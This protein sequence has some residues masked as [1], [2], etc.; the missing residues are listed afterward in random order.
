MQSVFYA[1]FLAQINVSLMI[2]Y[3]YK[4]LSSFSTFLFSSWLQISAR[5]ETHSKESQFQSSIQ[6]QRSRKCLFLPSS[7]PQ[8]NDKP[9]QVQ[10][11]LLVQQ[12]RQ[13]RQRLQGILTLKDLKATPIVILIKNSWRNDRSWKRLVMKLFWRLIRTTSAA[14]PTPRRCRPTT[15]TA[16]AATAATAGTTMA[17]ALATAEEDTA[18]ATAAGATWATTFTPGTEAEEEEE[19]EATATGEAVDLRISRERWPI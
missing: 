10:D 18:A 4:L 14:A 13:L 3:R 12:W 7:F 6:P 17:A 19:E 9:N 15:P 2:L 8:S 16:A 11:E 5:C 1:I